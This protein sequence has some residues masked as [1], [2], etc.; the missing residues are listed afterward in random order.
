MSRY[1]IG[2]FGGPTPETAEAG[3]VAV[4]SL[5]GLCSRDCTWG[6]GCVL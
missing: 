5:C 6:C 1:T 2:L 4:H 3:V